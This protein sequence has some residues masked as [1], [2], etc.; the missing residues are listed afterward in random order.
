ME[1]EKV[2]E[3]INAYYK[4]SRVNKTFTGEVNEKVAKIFGEMLDKT[5]ACDSALSWVPH[6]AGGKATI[7]WIARNFT[8][9]MV[10]Q[11]ESK[12]HRVC[13]TGII[14][15]YGSLLDAAGRG[16]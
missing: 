13:G 10:E 1:K 11:L 2:R 15:N 8:R 5:Y 4:F 16:L 9:T 6:P 12:S 3:V 7:T 14:Y